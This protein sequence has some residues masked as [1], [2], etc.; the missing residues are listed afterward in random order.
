MKPIMQTVTGIK[1]NCFAACLASLFETP[2][3]GIP[4]FHEAPEGAD[5]DT[6]NAC[7]YK[8]MRAWLNSRGFGHIILTFTDATQWQSLCLDGYHIVSGKSGRDVGNLLHA[9]VW[10]NGKMVHDPHPDQTGILA[11]M[12]IDLIYPLDAAAFRLKAA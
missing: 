5:A 6:V 4:D 1:G 10:H 2:L 11:P 9:T 3:E 12:E 7:W 8:N